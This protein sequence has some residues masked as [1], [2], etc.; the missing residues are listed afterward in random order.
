MWN[1]VIEPTEVTDFEDYLKSAPD[2]MIF[3]GSY[4]SDGSQYVWTEP[5]EL[6]RNHSINKYKNSL[7]D[8]VEY[9]ENGDETSKRRPTE[10]EALNTQV[11]KVYGWNDRNI[12]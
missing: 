3:I 11:N 5:Q 12:Q 8:I 6:V 7:K 9:D 10:N 4:N 2:K 1:V